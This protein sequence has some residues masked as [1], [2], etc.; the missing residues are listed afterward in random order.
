[1]A[2][3]S[4]PVLT[5]PV[6][7]NAFNITAGTATKLVFT[8][9]PVGG[10]LPATNFATQPKASVEDANSNVV[11][12][13][14]G[15]VT[16]SI[17]SYVVGN[18][19]TTQGTLACATNPINAVAG[20]ATFTG[21]KINGTAA[22]GTYTLSAVRAGLTSATS[23]SVVI[24]SGVASKLVF[25][26][27]PVGG[28]LPATNFP[29]QPKVSVEDAN[30]NVVTSDTGSVTLSIA[31]Y[32]PGNGGTI[33][34]TLVCTTNPVNAVAGV[35]TFAGCQITG[36]TSAGTYTLNAARSGLAS[37]TSSSVVIT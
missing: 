3:T 5:P 1:L 26:T 32:V 8:T 11:T 22:A 29:T 10:V 23:S 12:S 21:C 35:A 24:T 27:Q 18:G 25:T 20:V 2:A 31:S 16:L 14:T 36:S 4:S 13:D 19:G 28:V 33:Q 30:G 9:Q 34:G 15:S 17:A 37:G 6:N 7:A